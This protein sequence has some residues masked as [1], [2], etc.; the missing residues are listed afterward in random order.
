MEQPTDNDSTYYDE[1]GICHAHGILTCDM[2]RNTAAGRGQSLSQ[3]DRPDMVGE[4]RVQDFKTTAGEPSQQEDAKPLPTTLD[5]VSEE[6]QG[7]LSPAEREAH[8]FDDV[9][10]ELEAADALWRAGLNAELRPIALRYGRKLFTLCANINN[11]SVGLASLAQLA[12]QTRNEL[13][14]LHARQAGQA[15]L[16]KAHQVHTILDHAIATFI[17]GWAE[18]CGFTREQMIEVQTDM[19]RA[20]QLAKAAP[21]S[22]IVLPS[23]GH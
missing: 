3:V 6:L 4:G 21:P 13:D 5:L 9:N 17:A 23:G 11:A 10:K 2:C 1:Q 22:G 18:A 15:V 20:T 19:A 16:K 7:T 8:E 14:K 12:G